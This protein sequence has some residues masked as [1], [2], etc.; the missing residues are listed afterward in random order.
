[1]AVAYM[2]DLERLAVGTVMQPAIRE[3]T[4]HVEDHEL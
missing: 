4:I 2:K 1:M 3:H